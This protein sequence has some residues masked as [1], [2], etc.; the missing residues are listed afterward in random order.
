MFPQPFF[1]AMRSE[2]DLTES[3]Q[4]WLQCQLLLDDG[5]EVCPQC[6]AVDLGTYCRQCGACKEEQAVRHV[7]P[8]CHVIGPGSY[9]V[10]CGTALVDPVEE[11][12][13]DGTFNWNDWL[14]EL[15]PFLG[16]LTAK[17]RAVLVNEA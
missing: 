2:E 7:C 5:A 10:H 14:E 4:M 6:D 3:Q 16:G 11:S 1:G 9:C 17:E 8:Q 15:T 13:Q 12:L